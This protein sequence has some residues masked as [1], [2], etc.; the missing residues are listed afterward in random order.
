[1][2]TTLWAVVRDG[3]IQ[4][5]QPIDLPEGSKV[6]VTLL[7]DEDSQFWQQ[8]SQTSLDTVWNN[9]E[10]DIYGQLLET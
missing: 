1:M 3:Q 8:I 4:L 2:L 7:P 9:A 10:D 5:S 6:L